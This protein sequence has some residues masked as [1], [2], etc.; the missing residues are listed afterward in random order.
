MPVMLWESHYIITLKYQ[1]IGGGSGGNN[2][3]SWN[4][5]IYVI[6]RGLE[7]LNE[8]GVEK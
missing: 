3:R 1:I 6:N 5:F 8:G 7:K 4:F 2:R